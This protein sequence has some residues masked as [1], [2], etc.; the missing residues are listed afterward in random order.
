MFYILII[1][2]LITK[3]CFLTNANFKKIFINKAY[4]QII[5][6]I[7]QLRGFYVTY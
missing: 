5:S 3:V 6:K 1:V 2:L 4:H 7:N